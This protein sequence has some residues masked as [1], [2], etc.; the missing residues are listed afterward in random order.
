MRHLHIQTLSDIKG[1]LV[2]I[3]DV[4]GC[5]DE[6]LALLS[7]LV[8]GPTDTIIAAGD[9]I[10]RGPKSREVLQIVRERRIHC[11]LGNHELKLLRARLS[12]NT[13]TLKPA[14]LA[15]FTRL[16]AAD[17]A[18]IARWPHVIRVPQFN[19]L[20]VHGGFM[21]G[22]RWQNQ[23]PSII[24]QLQ[25]LD[26]MGRPRKRKDCPDGTLWGALWQGPERVVFGHT[27]R[28]SVV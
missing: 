10:N 18:E 19:L 11:V 9:V 6:L 13:D 3:G 21:P 23:L 4:H 5:A 7:K 1:R 14:D 25:V 17:F 16:D 27:D 20:V 26:Y 24:T 15:S 22:V 12:G 28:K 2:I 8:S